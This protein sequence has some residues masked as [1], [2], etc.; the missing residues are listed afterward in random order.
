MQAR[1]FVQHM[2]KQGD[3]GSGGCYAHSLLAHAP[4]GT[5]LTA[6]VFDEV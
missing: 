5:Q 2:I 3:S 4:S 1:G 6:T